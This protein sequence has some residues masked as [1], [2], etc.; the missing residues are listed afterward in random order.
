MEQINHAHDRLGNAATFPDHVRALNSI[1]VERYTSYVSDG[2]SEYVG[3]DGYTITSPAVHETLT[4][5]ETSNREQF[6]DHLNRHNQHK[7]T[8]IK[9]SQ[10]LAESGI[11]KWT[12]DTTRM[13]IT[14][15]DMAGNDMLME[16][17]N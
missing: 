8:Y 2:H 7:T 16:A 15:Y 17:I 3:R 13:T 12:V 11:E 5:A 10:G 1:G 9:M 6:L 14:F 4:I